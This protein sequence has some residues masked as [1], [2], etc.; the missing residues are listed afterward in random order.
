MGIADEKGVDVGHERRIVDEIQQ[1]RVVL[2]DVED[3]RARP[4]D[5]GDSVGRR[6]VRGFTPAPFDD[7]LE[8]LGEQRHVVR[9]EKPWNDQVATRLKR[10]DL[11]GRGACGTLGGHGRLTL[12]GAAWEALRAQAS[13]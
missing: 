10:V 4:V 7:G 5:V 2:E 3:A 11:V 9:S 6:A 8:P 12:G 1:G 13:G